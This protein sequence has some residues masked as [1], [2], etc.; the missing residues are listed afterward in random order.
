MIGSDTRSGL[1]FTL[2]SDPYPLEVGRPA[3][4]SILIRDQTGQGVADCD[5][6]LNRSMPGMEMTE[7]QVRHTARQVDEGVYNVSLGDFHMGGGWR[8]QVVAHCQGADY[9][10]TFDQHIPWP[11]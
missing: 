8:F 2:E 10:L 4:M 7:D 11:E 1:E 9:R 5:A 6:T 3:A